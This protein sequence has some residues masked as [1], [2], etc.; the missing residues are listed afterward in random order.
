MSKKI[1]ALLAFV[2][3]ISSVKSQTPTKYWV[4]LANKNGTPY[5][6]STP[7]AFLTPKSVQRR[8]AQGIAIDNT[9]L[10]VT[11]SYISQIE[12]ITD[13]KVLYASKWLNAVVVQIANSST[14]AIP[15]INSLSFVVNS[16]PVNKFK[17]VIEKEVDYLTANETEKNTATAAGPAYYGGAYWQAKQL[18]VD[19]MHGY[20]YRGQGMTIAVLDAGFRNVDVIQAFDSLE[21]RGGILGTR[22][23]VAGGNSVYEDDSHGMSVLSCMAALVPN[24]MVGTAPRA[25]YWLLRT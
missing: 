16:Q 21:N 9:D 4:K 6:I 19:C 18:N 22:D 17:L 10:P 12:A 1:V 8:T 2:V 5:S 20:G 25:D 23:F 3:L 13:V 24:V 7:T 15:A 11:P 14:A